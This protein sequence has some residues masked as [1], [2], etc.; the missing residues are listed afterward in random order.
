MFKHVG[1]GERLRSCK[2][3]DN[4]SFS[5][6]IYDLQSENSLCIHVYKN[7]V[8]HPTEKWNTYHKKPCVFKK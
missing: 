6:N 5:R 4:L 1:N 2:N 7:R 8:I 3:N